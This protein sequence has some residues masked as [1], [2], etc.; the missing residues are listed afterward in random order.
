MWDVSEMQIWA[1]DYYPKSDGIVLEFA[2][3]AQ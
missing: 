3:M 2:A 1:P